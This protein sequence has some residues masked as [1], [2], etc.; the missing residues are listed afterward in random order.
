MAID[1]LLLLFSAP[2]FYD[3]TYVLFVQSSVFTQAV[4]VTAIPVLKVL[5]AALSLMILKN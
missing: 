1:E 4:L 3:R 5:L 2:E